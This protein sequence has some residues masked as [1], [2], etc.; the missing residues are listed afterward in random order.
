[1]YGINCVLLD[2]RILGFWLSVCLFLCVKMCVYVGFLGFVFVLV[3]VVD[4]MKCRFIICDFWFVSLS[5]FDRWV[6]LDI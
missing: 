2:F 6:S 1:M 4:F 3:V 5:L